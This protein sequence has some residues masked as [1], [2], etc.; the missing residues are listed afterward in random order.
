MANQTLNAQYQQNTNTG[1]NTYHFETNANQVKETVDRKFITPAEKTQINNN[2]EN[3]SLLANDFQEAATL[4]QGTLAEQQ[5][6]IDTLNNE[7]GIGNSSEGKSL[8]ER[9]ANLEAFEGTKDQALGIAGL[10]ENG[11]IKLEQ[12]P[13]TLLGQLEYKGTFNASTGKFATW[14][15]KG[16]LMGT[17]TMKDYTLATK[18]QT[19]SENYDPLKGKFDTTNKK[20]Y[21][22]IGNYWIIA[23]SGTFDGIK[24]DVGDW[25]IFDG[26]G[27]GY[28]KVDN[29]DAVMSVAGLI[30]NITDVALKQALGLDK[31]DNI[32]D[33]LKAVLSATK[34]A[35][36]RT[37]NVSGDA[38][39]TAQSFD[40]TKNIVI[41]ITLGDGKVTSIKIAVNAV[42]TDK[43]Q[44][45]AITTEK[46]EDAAVTK[47]KI[48]NGAVDGSKLASGAV[49]SDKLAN[50]G[51]TA[52]SYS[53]VTVDAKG[54]VTN[55]SQLITVYSGDQ[56]PASV[57]I[58]GFAIKVQE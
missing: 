4:I 53:F 9:V 3:I 43:I 48:A 46:L 1:T 38:T 11:K 42:T 23:T 52:G 32:P 54:R 37:F 28:A 55:G 44:D 31:V 36:A 45:G 16:D 26:P 19:Q 22:A 17:S 40:G 18:A 41:P 14:S 30:G 56:M 58:G 13:D 6:A 15:D 8:N 12:I 49:T 57:P 10:D 50:S 20:Y 29:S 24:Y 21:P 34:L 35:T 7:V 33:S 5:T 39:G 47:E 25:I 51:V 27:S 2:T